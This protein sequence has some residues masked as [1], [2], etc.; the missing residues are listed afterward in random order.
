M[1]HFRLRTRLLGTASRTADQRGF[2]LVE[3]VVAIGVVALLTGVI[4]I[5][6]ISYVRSGRI[7]RAL[8]DVMNIGSAIQKFETDMARHPM[9]TSASLG[10][11][12]LPESAANVVRLE[13][14][15]DLGSEDAMSAWTAASPTDSDCAT[16]CTTDT[17]ASQLVSNTPGYPTSLLPVK[18][19][20]WRG[21]YLN[22]LEA[23]PWGNK[24][25][26]NI[27]NAKSTS[28]DAVFVLSP[29]P[30]G[31]IETAFNL[32]QSANFGPG[33]DDILYRIK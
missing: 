6:A 3:I 9:F 31:K 13:G 11:G 18:P 7:A 33:G 25:L 1:K 29:G 14:P 15:G 32:P 30:N 20:Q 2:S 16:N 12:T 4:S 27:I 8:S 10:G 22:K 24:Y 23:D 21:P 19:F 26:V 5:M 17:I 28:T